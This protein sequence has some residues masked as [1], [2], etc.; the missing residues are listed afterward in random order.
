MS[1]EPALDHAAILRVLGSAYG[2]APRTL[3]FIPGGTAPAYRADGTHGPLFVKVLPNT[4]AGAVTAGRVAA[5][6]PLLHA[7]HR[8]GTLTRVPRPVPTLGGADL[9]EVEG[10]PLVAFGWIGGTSLGA[11]WEAAL[12]ELAP[13]LGRLHA[14][15]ARVTR[16]VSRLPVPPEDFG[17]PFEG[18]LMEDLRFLRDVPRGV[19]PGVHALRGLLLPR[20][21]D[22]RRLLSRARAFQAAARARP[23]PFVL[24]HTDAHGGNVMRDPA[25]ELWIIDWETARLAPPEH[26]LWMLHARLPEVLPAYEEAVGRG[27]RLDPGV[28]GLYFCRRVLEDLAFDVDLILHHNTRPE[29]DEA[30]LAVVERFVLPGLDRVEDDLDGLRRALGARRH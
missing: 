20:E 2:L 7:L 9:T 19:R 25:G 28:L 18:G 8:S 23:P 4:A 16:G 10:H 11:G 27:V 13:L 26:D 1:A 24:C 30:N 5:E 29:E 21:D 17:L 12:G 15:T 6:V 22:L 14:G 3:T